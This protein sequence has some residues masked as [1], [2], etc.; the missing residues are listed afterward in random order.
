MSKAVKKLYLKE[1]PQILTIVIKRF[2]NGLIKN[3]S[4]VEFSLELNLN[5]VSLTR[6]EWN[7]KLYAVV[8]HQ[9]SV[10]GGHYIA[11]TRR[12]DNWYY[13]SDSHCKQT[14]WD[15][16]KNSQAYILFYELIK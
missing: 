1:P 4:N 10:S 3:N 16:V 2:T 12:G 11:Y 13:F 8:V 7:Y 5:G 14:T 9:G 15:I 6:D